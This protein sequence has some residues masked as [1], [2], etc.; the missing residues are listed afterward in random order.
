LGVQCLEAVKSAMLNKSNPVAA[1]PCR[2][3]GVGALLCFGG[4][5]VSLAVRDDHAADDAGRE[6][7]ARESRPYVPSSD[8]AATTVKSGPIAAV[9]FVD[10]RAPSARVQFQWG[11]GSPMRGLS[12]ARVAADEAPGSVR[13]VEA[14]FRW[15]A[16]LDAEGSLETA[17]LDGVGFPL[18]VRVDEESFC[19]LAADRRDGDVVRAKTTFVARR[20]SADAPPAEGGTFSAELTLCTGSR[21]TGV[22]N[23][24]FLRDSQSGG[25]LAAVASLAVGAGFS[26]EFTLYRRAVRLSDA[27]ATV[28]VQLPEEDRKEGDFTAFERSI[29][30][31]WRLV[32][33]REHGK[34]GAEF[35]A[36]FEAL[37]VTTI[38]IEGA[39]ILRMFFK[40][41]ES[42]ELVEASNGSSFETPL[43]IDFDRASGRPP[44]VAIQYGRSPEVNSIR[45][46]LAAYGSVAFFESDDLRVPVGASP[47]VLRPK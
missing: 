45:L 11:D 43:R 28:N 3:I 23:G 38:A 21:L 18:A 12:I 14:P 19:V 33:M 9:P 39:D 31:P 6:G 20:L 29:A 32:A 40:P 27:K 24:G 13:V 7:G 36:M 46:R 8:A 22:G 4:W 47:I 30:F 16:S 1:S 26:G 2:W 17:A 15:I 25:P 10:R 37:P 44:R 41:E 35:T 42:F 5:L 34:A